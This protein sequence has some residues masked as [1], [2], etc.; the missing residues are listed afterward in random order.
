MLRS[1]ARLLRQFGY[2]SKLFGSAATFADQ[3]DFQEA[4]CVILDIDLGD[5]SGI[6]QRERLNHEHVELRVIYVPGNDNPSAREAALRP[7]CL[8]YLTKPFPP[9]ELIDL[10]QIAQA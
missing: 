8:G 9:R 1:M 4:F 10:L 5:G 6:A 7:G 3:H 2:V